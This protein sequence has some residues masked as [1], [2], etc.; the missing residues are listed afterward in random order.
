MEV[1]RHVQLH[2]QP[3]TD[4]DLHGSDWI[5][6]RNEDIWGPDAKEF[7]PSRWVDEEGKLVKE[8]QWKAHMFNGGY[9][10]C[11]GQD[12]AKFEAVAV[13]AA[14]VREFD[15]EFAPGYSP[16]LAEGQKTP[17]YRPSLTLPMV[18]SVVRSLCNIANAELLAE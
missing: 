15:F 9:R 1:K 6:N 11:L 2:L 3:P 16:E 5:M 13:L 4:P 12:L 14:L 8:S 17:M 10:L 18:R 7:K